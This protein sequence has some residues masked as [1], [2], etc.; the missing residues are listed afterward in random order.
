[1]QNKIKKIHKP[2]E[3]KEHEKLKS[4][5]SGLQAE[6]KALKARLAKKDPTSDSSEKSTASI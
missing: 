3:R 2:I 1:M 6:N 5:A 4:T